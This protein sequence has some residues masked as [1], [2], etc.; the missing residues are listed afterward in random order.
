MIGL[1]HLWRHGSLVCRPSSGA[2]SGM[3][4]DRM[5]PFGCLCR[6]SKPMRYL[7]PNSPTSAVT[8][9]T[10]VAKGQQSSALWITVMWSH[11][12]AAVKEGRRG[13]RTTA[14][15]QWR[16]DMAYFTKR[17]RTELDKLENVTAEISDFVRQ[18]H[19]SETDGQSVANNLASLLQRAAGTSVREIDNVIVELQTL[20]ERLQSDGARVEREMVEYATLS[21]STLQSTKVISEC[22]RNRFPKRPA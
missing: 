15:T 5:I 10:P 14:L 16:S 18:Q 17:E 1:M 2:L 19:D 21:Q 11:S 12:R 3:R 9:T 4:C 22:L 6:K 7:S 8:K 13:T 20:R